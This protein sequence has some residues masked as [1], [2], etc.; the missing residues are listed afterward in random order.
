MR[1]EAYHGATADQHQQHVTDLSGRG[2]GMI[3]LSVYGDSDDPRYAAVWVDRPMPRWVAVHGVG[4]AGYQS[5]FD[6]HKAQ[7]YAPS[8]VSATG[9][10]DDAVFAAVMSQGVAGAW[11]A[12]H[13]MTAGDFTAENSSASADGL[14]PRCLAIYGDGDDHTYAAVWR[15]NPG[16]VKW[17]VHAADPASQY[18][19]TF[20]AET[21]LPGYTLHAWRPAFVTL[22]SDHT[23][24]SLFADDVVGEWI[25]RHNLTA[26][27]YQSEFETQRHA[28]FYPICVQGGGS[29]SDTRYAA[30]FAEAD[31]PLARHWTVTG[32]SV[33]ALTA[34]DDAMQHFMQRN[35]VRAA[36]VA[37]GKNGTIRYARAFTWAEAGY[38]TT[39]P[40]DRFLL[41]SC[42]KM[43]C[44]AVVQ[45]LYD[46]GSLKPGTKAYPKLGF[47]GPADHRSDDIT[48]Q[49]LL[50]HMGG[51]DDSSAGSNFDPTYEMGTIALAQGLNRPLTK[52][53]VA[54]YMYA[55]PLDFTPGAKSAYSNYGYLLLAAVVEHVTG[56]D[57]VTYLRSKLL[58]PAH[59][60]EVRVISTAASGRTGD[61][62]IAE[63][64][65][66][67]RNALH[68]KS[69][70]L[71]P[72]VYGG[73]GEINEV[74]V[75]ND[76]LGASARALVQFA[77]LHAAWG[78]GP[79]NPSAREGST[80][81]ASTFVWSRG[82]GIDAAFTINTRT[83]P[84][85]SSSKLVDEFQTKLDDLLTNHPLP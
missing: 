45:S 84:P 82:D 49:Q 44:E 43:F 59:I 1:F 50:D 83:W 58:D 47:S 54:R 13:G 68:P 30:V 34:V 60:T 51:Y 15:A 3:S 46:D 32:S 74:G 41:A 7:G 75:A 72:A 37:V 61:E 64:P 22:S 24:C 55:R 70:R 23:Y 10:G 56:Q 11:K 14:M 39:Q 36:Q 16:F 38:R 66:L 4:P 53:D 9:S 33:P 12:R 76:G 19:T 62:A 28:G 8:L 18:Q 63:D 69:Q 81:G 52:L 85:G 17:H 21:Q 6:A 25:A 26:D 27:Q 67:G 48:V 5:W 79:R 71:V 40:S 65:G 29:G 2:F 42:S 80:P 78:N 77:H 35:G 73:D 31:V 57:Y 20:D